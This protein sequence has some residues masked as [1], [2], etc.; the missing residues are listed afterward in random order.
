MDALLRLFRAAALLGPLL[1]LSALALAT[2]PTPA[3]AD[4][5]GEY[6]PDV[7][8][9]TRLLEGPGTLQF[10]IRD[11][12]NGGLSPWT[13]A[14]SM[15]GGDGRDVLKGVHPVTAGGNAYK[16]SNGKLYRSIGNGGWGR[17]RRKPHRTH[18]T[19][20]ALPSTWAFTAA[21]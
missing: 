14:T 20:G 6:T 16:W 8:V 17:C 21:G 19:K 15:P 13:D 9:E 12:K 2:W 5:A 18:R 1:L 11:N 4:S 7:T 3:T 10:R